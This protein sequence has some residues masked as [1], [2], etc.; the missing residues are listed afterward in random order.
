MYTWPRL[1]VAH[2]WVGGGRGGAAHRCR[3]CITAVGREAKRS[4]EGGEGRE[5]GRGKWRG[6]GSAENIALGEGQRGASLG[7]V[8]MAS[9][10]QLER[11]TLGVAGRRVAMQALAF[12][13]AHAGYISKRHRSAQAHG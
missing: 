5:R 13:S 3:R 2:G 9:A 10:W 6:G 12:F 8:D 1:R 7:N 11:L 4:L